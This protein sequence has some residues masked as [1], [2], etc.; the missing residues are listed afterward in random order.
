MEI[1][2]EQIKVTLNHTEKQELNIIMGYF[3]AKIGK[4]AI[5][6]TVGQFELRCRYDRGDYLVQFC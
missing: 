1:F 2:Y 4:G 6:T 3:N 5:G